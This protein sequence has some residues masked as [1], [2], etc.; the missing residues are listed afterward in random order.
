MSVIAEEMEKDRTK[1]FAL[2]NKLEEVTRGAV[3][4]KEWKR[5]RTKPTLPDLSEALEKRAAKLEQL[6]NDSVQ[7]I[8]VI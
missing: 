1:A 8:Q 4:N 6:Y 5:K 3:K 7:E 2:Q